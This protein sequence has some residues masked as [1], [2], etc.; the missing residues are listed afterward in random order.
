MPLPGR[1]APDTAVPETAALDT[2]APGPPADTDAVVI[3]RNEGARLAACLASLAGRVRR[4]VYV[5]SGSTD[6]SPAAAR[7]AGAMVVALDLARPFTAARARNAGLAALTALPDPPRFV[8]FVDGDC[9]LR[10]GWLA[11]A[12]AFLLAAPRAAVACGRRRER[13]PEA[14]VYNHLTDWEWDTPVGRARACGGDALIRTA[15]LIAI[16]GYAEDVIAAEDDEMCLRLAAA[17][18]EVWRLDAEMTWHDA[19]LHR[20]GPWWRRAVRAGHGF[21]DVGRR[22]PGYFAAH[23]RRA[24]IWGAV[25]PAGLAAGAVWAPPLALGVAALYGL[26]FA[27]MARRFSD[28]G[29]PGGRAL[30]AAGLMTA[31]KLPNLVGIL[32]FWLRRARGR[33]VAIIEYK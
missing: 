20:F 22:H 24:W 8:Q 26:S 32:T 4:I 17:G 7:A 29:M 1:S 21:A 23:R 16:G 19:A 18:W 13:H 27:R 33:G 25:L 28:W 9:T 3:G 10:E 11:A 5:D 15:A 6:G 31:V 12:R 14:S 30:A 2:A